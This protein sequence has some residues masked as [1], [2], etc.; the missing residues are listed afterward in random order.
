MTNRFVAAAIAALMTFFVALSGQALAQGFNL[1]Q[2]LGGGGGGGGGDDGGGGGSRH[3]RSDGS[4]VSVERSAPP[5]T[6]KFTG[7]QEDRGAETTMT[8]QFACYPAHDADIP[9]SNA[10]L[11]YTGGSNAGSPPPRGSSDRGAYGPPGGG[12]GYGPPDGS[13]PNGPPSGV[14]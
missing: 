7:K 3:Q 1:G 6:G 8:A 2:L 14:E 13:A 10:F 12:P 5:F 11:C 4:G 9:Q